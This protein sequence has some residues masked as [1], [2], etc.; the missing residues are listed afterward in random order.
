MKLFRLLTIAAVV[1]VPVALHATPIT[2]TESFVGSGILGKSDFNDVLVTL[3]ATGD[4]TNVVDQ[5]GIFVI[6]VPT[7]FSIAGGAS[8]TFTDEIQVVSNQSAGVAGF[9]DI[10][11][12]LA[13]LFTT[14]SAFDSYNLITAIG[15]VD[16]T[17]LFN[18]GDAFKTSGGK[19]WI[20]TV[21]DSTFQ[22]VLGTVPEPSSLALFGTGLLGVVGVMRR[23]FGWEDVG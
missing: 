11:N 13:I 15:P 5:G 23:R 2:Y 6:D 8:G 22:A 14:S 4:T 20:D 17:S 21:E 3:T 19:F 1:A 10:S 12:N 18:A 7:T 9:G 16:G